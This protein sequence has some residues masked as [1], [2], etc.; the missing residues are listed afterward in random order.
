M[1]MT[2]YFMRN[3]KGEAKY[4]CY[5]DVNCFIENFLIRNVDNSKIIEEWRSNI[6]Q[7]EFTNV[8]D[9]HQS[10]S[11]YIKDYISFS[12]K[13]LSNYIK[14]FINKFFYSH[15]KKTDSNLINIDENTLTDI[16]LTEEITPQ[17]P[18]NK[19]DNDVSNTPIGWE[20]LG[21][22]FNDNVI[23]DDNGGFVEK[24]RTRF[25]F[26]NTKI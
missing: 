18:S 6:N 22:T 14:I 13:K 16:P 4:K 5:Q 3:L 20:E 26:F 21:F 1:R 15:N 24:K 12:I 17:T 7:Q 9:K 11:K 2:S 25:N 23:I 8:F 19:Q 10:T